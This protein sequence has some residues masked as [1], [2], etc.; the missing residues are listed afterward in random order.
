[1]CVCSSSSSSI[2]SNSTDSVFDNFQKAALLGTIAI[3]RYVNFSCITK[4]FL[5]VIQ[6]DS[7]QLYMCISFFHEKVVVV[8]VVL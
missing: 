1:M 5:L 2:S 3:M 4:A 6:C 7:V 8:V